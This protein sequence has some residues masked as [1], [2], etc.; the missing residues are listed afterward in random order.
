MRKGPERSGKPGHLSVE[1][2]KRRKKNLQ[3]RQRALENKKA[4]ALKQMGVVA[5]GPREGEPREGEAREGK[6]PPPRR[7][8]HR[9]KAGVADGAQRPLGAKLG[10]KTGERDRRLKVKHKQQPPPHQ[11]KAAAKTKMMYKKTRKGQ[12]VMKHR[13]EDILSKIS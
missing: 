2:R 11:K 6:S 5:S 10:R 12:P 9:G 3:E 8:D 4:R 13:I 7:R 1:E